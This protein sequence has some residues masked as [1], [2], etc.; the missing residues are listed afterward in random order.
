MSIIQALVLGII[1][2]L[3]EF[4][5][6]SSSGHLV[7]VPYIFGWDLQPLYFDVAL[8]WGTLL[9]VVVFFWRDWKEISA[10]MLQDFGQ[11]AKKKDF[12]D[13]CL[14]TRLGILIGV[15]TIPAVILG[16]IF[17][18]IIEEKLRSP[19]V[20]IIM[21]VLVAVFM[22]W[23]E[24]RPRVVKQLKHLKVLD[25]FL[26]GLAQAVALIPGTSRSGIT[27]TTGIFR[28]LSREDAARFSFLLSTPVILGAGVYKL[29]KALTDVSITVEWIPLVIGF[30]VSAIVGLGV[31][32][33]LMEFIKKQKLTV[34]VIYRAILAGVIL[35]MVLVK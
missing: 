23:V 18:G 34:F 28:G 9:A 16:L 14:K 21:L 13:Y 7:L 25:G 17:Q 32:K 1:Q 35:V 6:V 20:I 30:V 24:Y 33:F 27:I 29:I 26:I 11:K 10:A 5:P 4:L 19:F 2:G 3:T 15:G 31:I 8:H 22:W 12:I